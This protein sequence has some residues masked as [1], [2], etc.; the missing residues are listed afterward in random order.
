MN[1]EKRVWCKRDRI[2]IDIKPTSR[3]KK[4]IDTIKRVVRINTKGQPI[5]VYNCNHYLVHGF[6]TPA[7]HIRLDEWI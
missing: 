3:H 2:Y 4:A 6:G 1:K 7:A 5:I